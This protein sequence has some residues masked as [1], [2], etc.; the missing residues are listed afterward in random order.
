MREYITLGATPC[1]EEC[2]QVGDPDYDD[3]SFVESYRYIALLRK[4]FGDPP[5]GP[6]YN[7]G[8]KGF[9][10]DFGTYHE[11]VVWYDTELQ[12]TVDFA[13][14]VENNLPATWEG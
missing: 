5:C 13:F 11:V 8:V 1:E 4:L 3:K 2:A 9:P 10:H 14:R 12:E 7:F 6:R